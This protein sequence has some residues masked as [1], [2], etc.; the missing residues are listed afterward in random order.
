LKEIYK[1]WL[2]LK[3]NL[4]LR[5]HRYLEIKLENLAKN[6]SKMLKDITDFCELENVFLNPPRISSEKVNYWEKSFSHKDKNLVKD[7]LGDTIELMGYV[8]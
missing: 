7:I 5:N 3:K 1:R 6:P 4:D 8:I 2:D